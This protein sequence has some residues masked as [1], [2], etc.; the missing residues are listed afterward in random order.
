MQNN[1]IINEGRL[2]FLIK[3]EVI[4]ASINKQIR[5]DY[6]QKVTEYYEGLKF[7][8][9]KLHT[10]PREPKDIRNNLL[11]N[12]MMSFNMQ[13]KCLRDENKNENN[14]ISPNK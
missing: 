8:C 7:M 14:T 5:L 10:F 4:M 9:E 13:I 3:D 11:K 2:N 1:Q 12:Y 6:F